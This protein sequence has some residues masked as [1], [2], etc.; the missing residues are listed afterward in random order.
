MGYESKMSNICHYK[1]KRIIYAWIYVLFLCETMTQA[2]S[3]RIIDE[4]LIQLMT[5]IV[6]KRSRDL[7]IAWLEEKIDFDVLYHLKFFL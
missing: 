5:L 1:S 7:Y 3:L 2:I 4:L 6:L